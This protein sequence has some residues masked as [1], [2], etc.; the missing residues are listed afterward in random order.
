MSDD[1]WCAV[2]GHL[3]AHPT[4]EILDIEQLPD[5][6]CAPLAPAVVMSWIQV[7]VDMLKVNTVL[8][9][10]NV[11]DH[12]F[13]D[14]ELFQSSARPYLETN[15]LRPRLLAIQRTLPIAYRGQVL[16]RA[17]LSSRTDPNRFW[18]L[19]SGNA[20]LAFLSRTTAIVT[21]ANLPTPVTAT[22][23]ENSSAVTLTATTTGS[24][25]TAYDPAPG[26]AAAIPSTCQKR[27]APTTLLSLP[28]L[29]LL[30]LLAS[31]LFSWLLALLLVTK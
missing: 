30:L 22:T 20:E 10:I 8:Y 1:T 4:L 17:L 2:C 18:M 15:W 12:D 29:G 24:L 25:P 14:Y 9:S 6:T 11:P 13:I 31:L 16:G 5:S 19:L 3:K 26:A 27:N 7:L 28:L 23:T 21:A